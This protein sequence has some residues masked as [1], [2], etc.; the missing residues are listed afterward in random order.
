M[1][2]GN[3]LIEATTNGRLVTGTFNAINA[4]T[5]VLTLNL[6]NA[7]LRAP[8]TYTGTVSVRACTNA[9]C[10]PG[11]EVAGSTKLINV[12]FAVAADLAVS[13]TNTNIT[14]ATSGPN[15]AQQPINVAAAAGMAWSASSNQPWLGLSGISGVGP[16][17]VNYIV[18]PSGLALGTYNGI[19]TFSAPSIGRTKTLVIT[20]NIVAPATTAGTGSLTFTGIAGTAVPSQS[21]NVTMNNGTP[22][23]WSATAGAAWLVA[24]PTTGTTPAVLTVG[25]NASGLGAGTYTS[26]VTIAGAGLSAPTTL[27]VSLVLSTP[28]LG[29]TPDNL[30]F[31]G[32]DGGYDPSGK[33]VQLSINTGANA[34]AWSASSPNA[35]LQVSPAAGSISA[36]PATITVKVNAASL[37]IGTHN[38]SINFTALVNGVPVNH[39]L[40]VSARIDAHKIPVSDVGVAL[41]SAPSASKLTQTLKVRS[42]RGAPI[43]WS[44]SSNQTWLTATS[45]GVTTGDLVLTA[46][47]SGLTA[48]TVHHA[49]VV[50]TSTDVSVTNIETV[51]IGLWVG[52]TTTTPGPIAQTLERLYAV[53]PIR[54]YAYGYD[55]VNGQ[56]SLIVLNIYNRGIVATVPIGAPMGTAVVAKDGSRLFVSD[57]QQR[58]IPIDLP[59]FAVGTPWA[60]SI[61][62]APLVAPP[63]DLEY[64]RSNGVGLLI[65]GNGRFYDPATGTPYNTTFATGAID[66]LRRVRTSRDGNLLCHQTTSWYPYT[67]SCHGLYIASD[68]PSQVLLGP[69]KSGLA[70]NGTQAGSDFAINWNGTR[71]YVP[72]F[73]CC[74]AATGEFRVFDATT[75]TATMAETQTFHYAGNPN[76]VEI[77]PDGRIFFGSAVAG[78]GTDVWVHDSNGAFLTSYELSSSAGAL[79]TLMFSGDGLQAIA[80]S[81]RVLITTIGP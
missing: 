38:G 54:P 45:S 27:N 19:L 17:T 33:T 28:T 75:S 6:P 14:Y 18:N 23:N 4:S 21:I 52:S 43:I 68:T 48:N 34:F 36:T 26:S 42:N 11:S 40:P 53:D 29:V 80:I 1:H 32:P 44:A 74:S 66:S 5:G 41:T 56:P 60:N 81:D 16:G 62:G 15:P 8:G 22:V 57:D 10:S 50:I 24:S 51:R 25:I 77:H 3:F 49:N 76:G 31:G 65:S 59:S 71:V 73:M 79:S 9:V 72:S 13:T 67:L 35:W 2:R 78:T 47:P 70:G 20:L 30:S 58:I 63:T 69:I 61:A 37:P 46:N 64:A 12:S 55:V 39:S 7:S